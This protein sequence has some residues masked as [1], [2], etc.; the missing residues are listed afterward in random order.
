MKKNHDIKLEETLKYA[1]MPYGELEAVFYTLQGGNH[2]TVSERVVL[3]L[4][5]AVRFSIE[6]FRYKLWHECPGYFE[7]LFGSDASEELN[8]AFSL[9]QESQLVGMEEFKSWCSAEFEN[10]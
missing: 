4:I 2:I 3:E 7:M 1:N 5:A 9:Y 8:K 10:V 6:P